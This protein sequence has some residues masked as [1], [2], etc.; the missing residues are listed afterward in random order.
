MPQRRMPLQHG[1]PLPYRT[2]LLYRTVPAL[3]LLVFSLC[4]FNVQ[5]ANAAGPRGDRW[6]GTWAT[7][8][9]ALSNSAGK[10]GG[11]DTTFREI[12]HVSLG[13]PAVRIIVSNEFGLDPLTV[14][15][16]N[17]ALSAGGGEINPDSASTLTFGGRAS[18]TIPPGAL[19]VSD[20][21][22]LKV[23]AFA[24]LAVSLFVP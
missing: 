16:A 13:G 22:N 12:V 3:A 24:D 17:I 15:A 11:A 9:V 2:T 4:C 5:P 19:A 6:V 18:V 21:A 10:F 7:S 23:P 20:P 1:T 8:P 14:G